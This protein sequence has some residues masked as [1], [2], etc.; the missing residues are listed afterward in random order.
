[1]GHYLHVHI[2]VVIYHV[3]FAVLHFREGGCWQLCDSYLQEWYFSSAA[4][5]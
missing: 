1:M 2:F 5:L 3:F 4:L